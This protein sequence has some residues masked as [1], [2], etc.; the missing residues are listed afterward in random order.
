MSWDENTK[1]WSRSWPPPASLLGSPRASPDPQSP[2]LRPAI[3]GC[4][5]QG[6]FPVP[7]LQP[8]LCQDTFMASLCPTASR[9]Y[10]SATIVPPHRS[11]KPAQ[12]RGIFFCGIREARPLTSAGR[13]QIPLPQTPAAST[14]PPPRGLEAPKGCQELGSWAGEGGEEEEEEEEEW[15]RGWFLQPLLSCFLPG[16]LNERLAQLS[17][18]HQGS[19]VWSGWEKN[20]RV[21]LCV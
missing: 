11:D 17:G 8:S 21:G 4:R 1:G 20:G 16:S 12:F 18:S 6:H 14:K 9:A 2:F 15:G 10:S 7:P 5:P 13:P 3:P 19:V